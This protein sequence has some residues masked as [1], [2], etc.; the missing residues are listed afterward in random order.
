MTSTLKFCGRSAELEQLV[1]RWRLASNIETPKPQIVVI[2]S[3][4]GVGKT[5]LALE[6]YRYLSQ[7]DDQPG[8]SGYWPDVTAAL[9]RNLEVSPD[10]RTC[11]FSV[12]IPYL[13]WG[14]RAGDPGAE[15]GVAGDAISGYDKFLA[16]HLVLMFVRAR[17]ENR[18]WEFAQACASV[19]IDIASSALQVD[20]ILTIGK[21]IFATAKILTGAIRDEAL[22]GALA[23]PVSRANAVLSDMEKV[24]NP[25]NRTYAKTPGVIFLDDAQFV[26]EKTDAAMRSFIEHVTH[27]AVT[28][29]W[30]IMILVTHWKAQLSPEVTRDQHS[31]A[32]VLSHAREGSSAEKESAAGLPG[33]YLADANYAEIDLSTISDLSEALG[34]KLPGL[35]EQQSK[36]ILERTGGNPRYLEQVIQFAREH[37]GFFEDFDSSRALTDAGL[38]EIL[39]ETTSQDIFKVV[40][41]R[42]I[43]APVEVQEAICLASLQGVRFA[44]DL[45]E[46]VAR[47]QTAQNVSAALEQA[48]DPW[49]WVAGM[50]NDS[51]DGVGAFVERL[52]Y[53]V[54]E[55]V[56]PH[57]KSLGPEAKLQLTFRD[58]IKLLVAD[59]EFAASARADTQL[60]AYG[61]AADLFEQSDERAERT[62]AQR[63]LSLV[64][65][66][67]LSRFSLE[68][69]TSAYE[70]LL[71]VEP[72]GRPPVE[73]LKLLDWL[74][75][76]YRKLRWRSKLSSTLKKIF[77]LACGLIDDDGRVLAFSGDERQVRE[78]FQ[79]WQNQHPDIS[80][81]AYLESISW[82]VRAL[83]GMS[84]LARVWPE[85][86]PVGS[87][88]PSPARASWVESEDG[89]SDDPAPFAPFVVKAL[90]LN[91][92]G[93]GRGRI[94]LDHIEVAQY[95]RDQ[96]YNLGCVI[97]PKYGQREHFKLLVDDIARIASDEWNLEAAIDALERALTIAEDLNDQVLQVQALSNLGMVHGQKGDRG[98]SEK[99]LLEA[100]R[101]HNDNYTGKSFEVVAVAN[102][103]HVEH[104]RRD[105][106][107]D[108]DEPQILGRLN[109]PISLAPLFDRE[110][111]EAVRQFRQLVRMGANIEGN[112][113]NK[114]LGAGEFEDAEARY[115]YALASYTDLND[116][117][118]I[119]R[120]LT[121][122]AAVAHRRGD[123]DTACDYWR[124]SISVYKKLK[125]LHSGEIIEQRWE[126]AI[127]E[128]ETLMGVSGC[129]TVEH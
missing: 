73:Y 40:R 9:D 59:E 32:G 119:A 118:S 112:L 18:A 120:T 97:H 3:E 100:G 7:T 41:R 51:G 106:V 35:T 128:L 117:P 75:T 87:D 12:P 15:N 115:K 20:N 4:R 68:S 91:E 54:A 25:R 98:Q 111:D 19:G 67:H 107:S 11:N 61:L 122:L 24:F 123:I 109:I 48:E 101:I 37:E 1:E 31:F 14:L 80:V 46:A 22:E 121:N 39:E 50:K 69:A 89:P 6:F 38:K 116:G 55:H 28:Q 102:G 26:D 45:V 110:P 79:T 57:V 62:L 127:Q 86:E 125:D 90:N 88:D 124:Q 10:P 23:K 5:R 93:E 94:D 2:K 44:K 82:I 13:W 17:M 104:K 66:V 83:L 60:I 70:R 64:A 58:A 77:W 96:A 99:I 105:A 108:S 92:T 52:F 103:N 78:Y 43:N 71:D 56:R 63:A 129:N 29:E 30:P 84:E 47:L 72:A 27:K 65:K 76:A 113:G 21:G 114:A 34:E 36:A 85:F 81:D 33:G 53:Q 8:A 49:S 74:S 42:L 16:P 95:M 126:N